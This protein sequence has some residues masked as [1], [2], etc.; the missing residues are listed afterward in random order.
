MLEDRTVLSTVHALFDLSAPAK[1]PFPSN[2][3]TVEDGTQN[4]GLRVNLPLPDL[5]HPS[6]RKDT[7]VLNKLDG[8]NMQPRLSIPFD[9]PID[10]NSVTSQDV[11]LINLGDTVDHQEHGDHVVGINQIVWDPPSKTLHVESDQLL[12]Q[13]TEYALIVTNGL[14][15][16]DG[17]PVEASEAFRNFR[18]DVRGEYKHELLDAIHAAHHLGVREGDIVTASVFT[19]ESATAILEKIRDQI[20]AATPAPAD[21]ILGQN[22]ERT[23]FDLNLVTGIRWNQQVRNDP[24]GFNAVD[25]NL[26]LLRDVIP[27]AVGQLAFGKYLSPDYEVHPGEYIPP[28]GTRAGTPKVQGINEIYFNLILPSGTKPA[29]GWPVAIVGHGTGAS[30][31]F[32]NVASVLA[33][34][35]IATIYING[36]G[37]GFGALGTLMVNRTGSAPV[38]FPD[39][40][41][42]FDQNGDHTITSTEGA[43]TPAPRQILGE[44]DG[45]RQ[46]VADLMQ[47]VRVIEVGMDVDGDG[48]A[49]LNPGRIY[50][51]GGSRGARYG[52]NFL[53]IEPD[54]HAGVLNVPAGQRLEAMRL[55]PLSRPAVGLQLDARTP[56]LLNEPAGLTSIGG[57]AVGRPYFNEN[58][59][60]RNQPPVVNDVAGAMAIQEWLDH[61]LWANQPGD[62]LAY[63]PHLRQDP[64]PGVLP[65]SV[66]IQFAK[67][68]QTNPNPTATALIRAGDLAG[69]TLYFRNDLA[70]A[71]DPK[72]VPKNPHGFA[73]P[74]LTKNLLVQAIARGAQEQVATFF[75]SDG[76]QIIHPEPARFFE[77]PIDGPL[78]EDLNYIPDNAPASPNS[79]APGAV[80][81]LPS[82]FPSAT[83]AGLIQTLSP[84]AGTVHRLPPLD[85]AAALELLSSSEAAPVPAVAGG[86]LPWV[87]PGPEQDGTAAASVPVLQPGEPPPL[88]PAWS[89][90]A[91]PGAPRPLLDRLFAGL[92]SSLPFDGFV[93]GGT[94]P[95]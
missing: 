61:T 24:P 65:K 94:I 82:E 30:K 49:D 21:F 72:N 3:F 5:A 37:H 10:V 1:G 8:F 13:H 25:L 12:D 85:L 57:V 19:T 90:R 16:A 54:V 93:D 62:A 36:V 89:W 22:G 41:R 76:A 51:L 70:F 44:A 26:S 55:G 33:A 4:T 39:G 77:V 32:L 23:V 75:A 67:G 20:H 73:A 84:P 6:D 53:A 92:E 14:Q 58:L 11:F 29:D 45:L 27:G 15:A 71:V 40:G 95:M 63:A 88:T 9:G 34:R 64:L 2:I 48:T 66:I 87:L 35:G 74:I 17:S 18:H 28:V 52:T 60:L 42:G 56:S 68:D 80:V 86:T 7:Q 59:P 69:R 46:T 31:Q 83:F 47:L 50:Y 81:S 91:A 38:T 78:P 79:A 43:D